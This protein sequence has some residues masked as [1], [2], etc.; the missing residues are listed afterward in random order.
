M[1]ACEK[2]L[3]VF[4]AAAPASW[5]KLMLELSFW[6]LKIMDEEVAENDNFSSRESNLLGR[7]LR[8]ESDSEID[9]TAW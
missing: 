4:S 7:A 8:E 3:F 5:K 1:A 9:D 6:K 2:C